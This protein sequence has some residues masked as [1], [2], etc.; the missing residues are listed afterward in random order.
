MIIEKYKKRMG[1]EK[2]NASNG[3]IP[4]I[5]AKNDQ[6]LALTQGAKSRQLDQ[7][8]LRTVDSMNHTL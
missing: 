3:H 6:L 5:T 4:R 2:Q 1:N 7:M 8:K